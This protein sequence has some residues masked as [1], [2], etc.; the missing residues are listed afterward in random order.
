MFCVRASACGPSK[1]CFSTL[2]SSLTLWSHTVEVFIMRMRSANV[3][4]RKPWSVVT[5]TPSS[6]SSQ[7]MSPLS[8]SSIAAMRSARGILSSFMDF[9]PM[10][11]MRS[12]FCFS[13]IGEDGDTEF[14]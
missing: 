9:N 1:S 14:P 12:A 2:T 10:A 3:L 6:P 4:S 7:P 11:I 13:T 5:S 8:S